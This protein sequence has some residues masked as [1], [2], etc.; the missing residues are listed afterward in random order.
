M[1]RSTWGLVVWDGTLTPWHLI[2]TSGRIILRLDTP[3][4]WGENWGFGWCGTSHI[5]DKNKG[6]LYLRLAILKIGT[7]W[8]HRLYS[9]VFILWERC[10]RC[11]GSGIKSVNIWVKSE[12]LREWLG[13]LVSPCRRLKPSPASVLQRPGFDRKQLFVQKHYLHFGKI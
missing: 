6:N 11:L 12:L 13:S 1:V 9:F 2:L 10:E 3:R 8:K 7:S 4:W 5:S